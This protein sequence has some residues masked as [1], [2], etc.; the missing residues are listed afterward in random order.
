MSHEAI[1]FQA[2]SSQ[3]LIETE[4]I[5]R[6]SMF[7]GN[8]SL[9]VIQPGH[10]ASSAEST[11]PGTTPLAR[12]LSAT[13]VAHLPYNQICMLEHGP[14]TQKAKDYLS[15]RDAAA[16]TLEEILQ[17][18]PAFK[19][20]CLAD[21]VLSSWSPQQLMRAHGDTTVWLS[22]INSHTTALP[23]SLR[24]MGISDPYEYIQSIV[25][26][27][28][29]RA[30]S[31]VDA[32]VASWVLSKKREL[33]PS[34][35]IDYDDWYA[36][37]ARI[38][39][40]G[41]HVRADM[42]NNHGIVPSLDSILAMPRDLQEYYFRLFGNMAA[43][44]DLV[45]LHTRRDERHL[46]DIVDHIGLDKS[47]IPAVHIRNL[48]PPSFVDFKPAALDK[49]KAPGFMKE[50]VQKGKTIALILERLDPIK[51]DP[52]L[53]DNFEFLIRDLAQTESGRNIL[54]DLRVA[55]VARPSDYGDWKV[56]QLYKDYENFVD[57]RIHQ[58]N[59]LFHE[60][61][62]T[63]DDFILAHRDENG[64]LTGYPH[65]RVKT[66]V[67][68]YANIHFQMGEEGLCQTVQEAMLAT[69]YGL[70]VPRPAVG[71]VSSG[72]GF[73]EK[74]ADHKFTNIKIVDDPTDSQAFVQALCDGYAM[75]QRI[76]NEP[77]S[78]EVH[79]VLNTMEKYYTSC[80]DSFYGE[81][82]RALNELQVRAQYASQT[83][84][85]YPSQ[86]SPHQNS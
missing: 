42:A 1:G 5:K 39:L 63:D 83:T 52:T 26:T 75:A 22:Y 58:V 66:E 27:D 51:M 15:A 57:L 76:K 7:G 23:T 17:S 30:A 14:I 31:F 19:I 62:E 73:A 71:I 6:Q 10:D 9:K 50:A 13:S 79:Q 46:M 69:A 33:G 64:R 36:Q 4:L 56:N 59:S 18:Q 8:K 47:V 20:A 82:L 24:A 67:Y 29:L 40:D 28:E 49:D 72:I 35:V 68:P 25:S 60:V 86:Q 37:N 34:S 74:A 54:N 61:M 2:P 44:S 84:R 81:A 53:M 11:R 43:Y 38:T 80:S 32:A 16:V 70:D 78:D 3:K 65:E 48:M 21:P 85:I 12:A 77:E 45:V 55:M 41:E